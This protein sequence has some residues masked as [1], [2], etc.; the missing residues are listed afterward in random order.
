MNSKSICHAPVR[1]SL[2]ACAALPLAVLAGGCVSL[3][4]HNLSDVAADDPVSRSGVEYRLGFTQLKGTVTWRLANCSK[5][6]IVIETD[7]VKVASAPDMKRRYLVDM[8]S[9][10][11]PVKTSDLKLKLWPDRQ[12]KSVSASA[13]DRTGPIIGSVLGSAVKLMTPAGFGGGSAA[14]G[15]CTREAYEA[16]GNA[17]KLEAD[18]AAKKAEVAVAEATVNAIQERIRLAGGVADPTTA[19]Q[20]GNAIA[21]RQALQLE[22][23]RLEAAHKKAL[24]A[25]TV[26]TEF[27][28]PKLASDVGPEKLPLPEAARKWFD[29]DPPV[30][31]NSIVN[32]SC[33]QLWL[34]PTVAG[35]LDDPDESSLEG[36]RYRQAEPATFEVRAIGRTVND[37]CEEKGNHLV[38][39]KPLDVLQ[40]GRI[41]TLPFRNA[42]F[43]NNGLEASWDEQG[44]LTE[45]GYGVKSA[46]AETLATTVGGGIDTIKGGIA[47]ERGAELARLKAENDLLE[48]RAKNEE[49]K[50][51]AGDADEE[52]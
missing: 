23:G 47:A 42:M 12:L 7:D 38:S 17:D 44:R 8:T 32:G 48:A 10:S 39:S 18:V 22:L 43:Q 2:L 19:H 14:Y 33:V 15:H 49:L 28:W 20:L 40:F 4:V 41:K 34:V 30:N 24:K 11:S 37:R 1:R 21:S 16:L 52:E 9:L 6:E 35:P 13:E 31:F 3:D 50:S 27:L 26:S 5:P 36:I 51:K 25:I 45:V 46:S 29:P